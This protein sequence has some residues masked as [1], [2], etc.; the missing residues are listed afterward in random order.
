MYNEHVRCLE[1]MGRVRCFE[2]PEH[3]LSFD[4]ANTFVIW[5]TW[6][7]VRVTNLCVTSELRSIADPEHALRFEEPEGPASFRFA[8]PCLAN[9]SIT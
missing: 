5:H 6:K 8:T 3:G 1:H 2:H 7:V 9:L 4:H